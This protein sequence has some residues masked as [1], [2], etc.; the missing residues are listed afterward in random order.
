MV[1]VAGL[2]I[3][4]IRVSIWS[5]EMRDKVGVIIAR[6]SSIIGA[7]LNCRDRIFHGIGVQVTHDQE[8]GVTAAGRIRCYPIHQGPRGIGASAITVTLSIASIRVTGTG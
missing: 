3:K 4:G 7:L 5:V 2:S 8:I 6:P 1:E